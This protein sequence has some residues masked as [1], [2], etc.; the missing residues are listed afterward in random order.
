MWIEAQGHDVGDYCRC[1]FFSPGEAQSKFGGQKNHPE[2]EIEY[3]VSH[4]NLPSS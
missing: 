1:F 4:L 3:S 2:I